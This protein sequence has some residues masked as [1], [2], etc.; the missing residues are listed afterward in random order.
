MSFAKSI[1]DKYVEQGIITDN[2]K[3]YTEFIGS[4]VCGIGL[5]ILAILWFGIM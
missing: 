5:G 2:T 4:I 1:I 3:D